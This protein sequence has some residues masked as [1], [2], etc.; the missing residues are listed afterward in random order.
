MPVVNIADFRHS[1]TGDAAFL[2]PIGTSLADYLQF[3]EDVVES[4]TR[5]TGLVNRQE[6]VKAAVKTAW[7]LISTRK[8]R[9]ALG[10]TIEALHWMQ[11]HVFNRMENGRIVPTELGTKV[12]VETA[13]WLL[14]EGAVQWYLSRIGRSLTSAERALSRAAAAQP[15]ARVSQGRRALETAR[16]ELA[17]RQSS[18][19]KAYLE[20]M[21]RVLQEIVSSVEQKSSADR[22]Q[23]ERQLLSWFA[24][25]RVRN[26]IR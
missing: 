18:A 23:D 13:K 20:Q 14:K 11:W 26:G 9:K 25:R 5:W 3:L 1:V 6:E 21:G 2:V 4:Q 16:I 15:A 22:T 10:A 8:G 7:A 24:R 17:R 19:R 12:T